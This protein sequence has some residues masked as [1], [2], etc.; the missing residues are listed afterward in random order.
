MKNLHHLQNDLLFY[1]KSILILEVSLIRG[2]GEGTAH[3]DITSV[4]DCLFFR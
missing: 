4:R 1:S 2:G 3:D